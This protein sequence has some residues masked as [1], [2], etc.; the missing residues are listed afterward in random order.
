MTSLNARRF[1]RVRPGQIPW[2]CRSIAGVEANARARA[3]RYWP[4][5][6]HPPTPATGST[7]LPRTPSSG[8]CVSV[9]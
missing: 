6:R 1:H 8:A 3:S 2:P 9:R 4:P 7:E 5:V